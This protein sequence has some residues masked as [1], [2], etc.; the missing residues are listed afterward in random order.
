MNMIYFIYYKIPKDIFGK[1]QGFSFLR[2]QHDIEF[3]NKYNFWFGLYGWTKKKSVIKMFKKTRDMKY[4]EIKKSELDDET[5]YE[6]KKNNM[7]NLE[8]KILP[9][10]TVIDMEKKVIEFPVTME[11]YNICGS[12]D[13]EESAEIY[14]ILGSTIDTSV[15]I[16]PNKF[17]PSIISA[18]SFL[19]FVDL[20]CDL[21][22]DSMSDIPDVINLHEMIR[23]TNAY[24]AS[25]N[26]GYQYS[27]VRT[28]VTVGMFE[29]YTLLFGNLLVGI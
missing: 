14:E 20:Y 29:I 2:N 18:L 3:S 13:L 1:I 19:G 24:N 23:E 25:Y 27:S 4:F 26:I 17:K 10:S 9:M 12:N 21:S 6:L 15:F 11:E 16:N 28:R 22:D 5:S 7:S 8:V